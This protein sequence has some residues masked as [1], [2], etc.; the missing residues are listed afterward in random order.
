MLTSW[1]SRITP[2]RF[3]ESCNNGTSVN[4]SSSGFRSETLKSV[5]HA[6]LEH[7]RRQNKDISH[8]HPISK[9]HDHERLVD[10]EKSL[11]CPLPALV[12]QC[13]RLIL[14]CGE[15]SVEISVF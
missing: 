14:S 3:I 2:Q 6:R 11:F 9:E 15:F 5:W 12:G 7:A 4:L 8:Q 10:S 1:S 13:E